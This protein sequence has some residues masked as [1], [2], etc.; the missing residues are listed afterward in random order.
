MSS[1][2]VA[3]LFGVNLF[4]HTSNTNG[5]LTGRLRGI[6]AILG[7][8]HILITRLAGHYNVIS[9]GRESK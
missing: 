2:Q 8:V 1:I 9:F 6:E 5:K 4:Y 7:I 3:L